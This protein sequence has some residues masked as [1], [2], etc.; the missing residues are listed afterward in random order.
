VAIN[1]ESCAEGFMRL[2][3]VVLGLV[4]MTAGSSMAETL[5]CKVDS[6]QGA[7]ETG[8]I[9]SEYSFQIDRKNLGVEVSDLNSSSS[10]VRGRL[11]G[12]TAGRRTILWTTF[13]KTLNSTPTTLNFRATWLMKSDKFIVRVSPVQRRG[14]RGS[15]GRGSCT[16]QK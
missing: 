14:F 2:L 9:G 12:M 11:D 4:V 15:E 13:A 5:R 6:V 16:L 7:T 3:G 1:P 8:W 10:A